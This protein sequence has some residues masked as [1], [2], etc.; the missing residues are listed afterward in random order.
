MTSM[1]CCS[2]RQKQIFFRNYSENH[3]APFA[4][5]IYILECNVTYLQFTLHNV[6]LNGTFRGKCVSFFCWLFKG[7]FST[8]AV[9]RRI[10]G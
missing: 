1:Q 5:M 7:A 10:V 2:S 4:C 3:S 6:I 9:I 8:M